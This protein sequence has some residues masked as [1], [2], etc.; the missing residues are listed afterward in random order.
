MASPLDS[1]ISRIALVVALLAVPY[2]LLR[3][4][5]VQ[6]F[7]IPSGSMMPTFEVGDYM[8]ATKFP[9]GFK[10]FSLPFGRFLPE[11]SVATASPKRADVAIFRLPG[12]PS[13]DYVMRIVGLPGETVQVLDGIT[14]INGIALRREPAGKYDTT[15]MEFETYRDA[16]LFREYTPEGSTYIVLELE[17]NSQGDNTELFTVPAGHY[18]VMGDN[19]DNSSD[20]R[21]R[22][23]Y[24]PE[25]NIY[26]K[27]T[28][29]VSPSNGRPPFRYVE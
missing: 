5:V 12:A 18:F 26:A 14:Y 10:N 9:Y 13:V 17:E 28:I 19:R 24:V 15:D 4:L 23:A 21:Y 25:A 22:V 8:I 3:A 29:A 7:S 2:V 20:S 11:F 1:T 27:A 16:P 6:P